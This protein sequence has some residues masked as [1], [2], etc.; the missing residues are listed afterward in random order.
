MV[1]R[2]LTVHFSDMPQDLQI[3]AVEK[4]AS[5]IESKT[6]INE[7]ANAIKKM[8]DKDFYPTWHCVVGNNFGAYVSNEEGKSIYF[9]YGQTSI[10]L[11]RAG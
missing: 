9:T 7:I 1:D 10:L 6:P 4:A 2:K 5:M 3:V 8:F 11:F